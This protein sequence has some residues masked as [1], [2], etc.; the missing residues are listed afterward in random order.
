MSKGDYSTKFQPEKLRD[1]IQAGRTAKQI[2]QEL[3]IS[4][5]TLKEHLFLLQRKDKKYYEIPGLL[6][7]RE[8]TQKMLRYR[9]GYVCLPGSNYLPSFSTGNV[10]EMQEHA[11]KIILQMKS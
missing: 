10:L 11:D 5:L 7:D 9:R 1:M 6:E 2:M 4:R 3:K 8:K